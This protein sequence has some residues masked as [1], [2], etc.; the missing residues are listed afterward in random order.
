MHMGCSVSA[1]RNK[2]ESNAKSLTAKCIV[3]TGEF[4]AS[5]VPSITNAMSEFFLPSSYPFQ[6]LLRLRSLLAS[7][8]KPALP[9]QPISETVKDL[10]D[11]IEAQAL[12]WK[13]MKVVYPNGHPSLGIVLAELG[14][15]LNLDAEEDSARKQDGATSSTE[16]GKQIPLPAQATDRLGLARETLGMALEQLSIGLGCTGGLVGKEVKGIMEG[17]TKE[18]KFKGLIA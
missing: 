6:P 18:M 16:I 5:K 1:F 14:K 7:Q 11:A 15:L 17:L 2:L 8:P 3:H 4:H 13:G 12:V 9:G 10:F